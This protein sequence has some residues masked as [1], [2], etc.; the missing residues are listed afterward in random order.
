MI[1]PSSPWRHNP[2]APLPPALPAPRARGLFADLRAAALGGAI[3]SPR[4][5]PKLFVD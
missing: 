3:G 2:A 4:N 5:S 1:G